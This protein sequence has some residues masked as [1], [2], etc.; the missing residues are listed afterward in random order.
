MCGEVEGEKKKEK[1]REKERDLGTKEWQY[2]DR[3]ENFA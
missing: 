3:G 1:E 2:G